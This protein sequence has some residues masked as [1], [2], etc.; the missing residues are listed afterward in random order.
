MKFL[1]VA[2]FTRTRLTISSEHLPPTR[3]HRHNPDP[4][5]FS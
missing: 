1:L 4:S 2:A 5:F 3:V